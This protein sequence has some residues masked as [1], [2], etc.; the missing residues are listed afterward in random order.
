MVCDNPE[1]TRLMLGCWHKEADESLDL[2]RKAGC[3]L[4]RLSGERDAEG[5]VEPLFSQ[6]CA[7]F[8]F[9]P[10][11]GLQ[12]HHQWGGRDGYTLLSAPPGFAQISFKRPRSDSCVFLLGMLQ[13]KSSPHCSSL[14]L[15]PLH[16]SQ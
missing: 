7:G 11:M 2:A 12:Q 15:Q 3:F 16:C 9:S 4:G 6:G 14:G 13:H 10:M 5:E 1:A 8:P